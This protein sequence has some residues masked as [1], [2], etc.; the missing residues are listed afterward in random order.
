ML[1]DE[2]ETRVR[3]IEIYFLLLQK[4]EGDYKIITDFNRTED[5]RID[6]DLSKILKANGFLL[7]YNLIEST[8]FNSIVEI[9][10]ELKTNGITY[11]AISSE[12]KKFWLKTKYRNQEEETHLNTSQKFYDYVEE[13]FKNLPI[14]L[15][16]N[17]IDYGGSID[18]K[19]IK[20]LSNDLGISFS[21]N[22]YK[23][24]PNGNAFSKIK[25]YRN[26]LAHGSH[27]FAYIGKDHTYSGKTKKGDND[28][29]I[30][31]EF[32]LAHFKRFTVEHLK[33]F[34]DAVEEYLRNKS[35]IP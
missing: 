20:D 5:F 24:Y 23:A 25:D 7:L 35:Y 27:S 9:F 30:V 31:T 32:G 1:R 33:V 4:I 13:I 15:I 3:E 8:L 28:E 34:V 17:R 16:V 12:L 26:K 29:E 11:N 18:A 10:D 6:D 19:K 22:N 21:D 14:E 2:F